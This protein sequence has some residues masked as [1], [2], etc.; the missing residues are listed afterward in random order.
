MPTD[1]L[2][3]ISPKEL[4]EWGL[5]FEINRLV[6]HPLGLA[7]AVEI[8][9]NGNETF[10]SKVWDYRDDPEGIIFEEET[11]N[12]GHT[13]LLT[14]MDLWGTEK[15]NSRFEQLGY[16][17]QGGPPIPTFDWPECRDCGF[18][19]TLF[20]E[21]GDQYGAICGCRTFYAPHPLEAIKKAADH[22]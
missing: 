17:Y 9:D 13:K 2:K 19:Y 21:E 3:Y 1:G 12:Q 14:T 20:E 22:E 15:H 5:L 11:F 10:S 8:D 7:L 6:L 16:V 4:R 18:F